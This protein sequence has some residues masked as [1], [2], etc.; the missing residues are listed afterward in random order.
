MSTVRQHKL[1]A[2]SASF[3]DTGEHELVVAASLQQVGRNGS[4]SL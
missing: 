1:E 4:T 3:V 2:C